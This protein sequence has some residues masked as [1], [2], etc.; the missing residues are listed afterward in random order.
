[1]E[2]LAGKLNYWPRFSLSFCIRT[3]CHRTLQPLP[4]VSSALSG[5]VFGLGPVP[6][7]PP[8]LMTLHL[9]WSGHIHQAFSQIIPLALR[10]DSPL[11]NLGAFS[12]SS[13]SLCQE[14]ILG[15]LHK[16]LLLSSHSLLFSLIKPA[17]EARG[18]YVQLFLWTSLIGQVR[19]GQLLKNVLESILSSRKALHP[20][21]QPPMTETA[22]PAQER[23]RRAAFF[24]HRA[25]YSHTSGAYSSSSFFEGGM[26]AHSSDSAA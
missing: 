22:E 12:S 14:S 18:S 1:M 2:N 6:A 11:L 26:E 9:C 4:P 16:A 3:L 15:P 24:Q 10:C 21:E 17:A 19:I 13:R 23:S 25:M 7:V 5:L 20:P 8:H